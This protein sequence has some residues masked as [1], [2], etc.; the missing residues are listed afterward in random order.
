MR[1]WRKLVALVAIA[2]IA[3]GLFASVGG[4]DGVLAC[5]V[6]VWLEFQPDLVVVARVEAVQPAERP[7]AFRSLTALRGPPAALPA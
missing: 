5:L 1:R 2:V 4:S 3:A 7:V 6:P